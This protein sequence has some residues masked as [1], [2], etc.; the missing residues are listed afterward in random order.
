M[1]H[2]EGA[3]WQGKWGCWERERIIAIED[4]HKGVSGCCESRDGR[5]VVYGVL[6]D[7]RMDGGVPQHGERRGEESKGSLVRVVRCF[8]GGGTDDGKR[9]NGAGVVQGNWLA[10]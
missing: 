6:T 1:G 3:P 5:A 8:I 9:V 10:G 7:D 2:W 4:A